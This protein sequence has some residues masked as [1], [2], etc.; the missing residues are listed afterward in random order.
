MKTNIIS[1]NRIVRLSE[2]VLEDLFGGKLLNKLKTQP[3]FKDTQL[4]RVA[5][6]NPKQKKLIEILHI[7]AKDREEK[8]LTIVGEK[9]LVEKVIDSIEK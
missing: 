2:L 7:N 4:I 8:I 6:F 9:G 3:E 5:L 1:E